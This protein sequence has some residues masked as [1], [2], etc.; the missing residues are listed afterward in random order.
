MIKDHKDLLQIKRYDKC[1][2]CAQIIVYDSEAV[3]RQGKLI[4]LAIDTK[5]HHCNGAQQ[6]VHEKRIVSEIQ[7]DIE[8]ANK[9]ELRYK[10][11]L[12][13]P[14]ETSMSLRPEEI[15]QGAI[16]RPTKIAEVGEIGRII[17]NPN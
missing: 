8:R 4:P 2:R 10:L 1:S 11:E 12:V 5:R 13:I 14:D 3:D 17:Q 9:F 15:S 6:I 7:A 16:Y